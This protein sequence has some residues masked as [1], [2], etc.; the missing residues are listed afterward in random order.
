[1]GEGESGVESGGHLACKGNLGVRASG[2]AEAS[3]WDERVFLGALS[4]GSR[5]L[6]S[7]FTPDAP[8]ILGA[9]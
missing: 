8:P 9:L 6:A 4:S 2:P 1:M 5:V 3:H 7:Q